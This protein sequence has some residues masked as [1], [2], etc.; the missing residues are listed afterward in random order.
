MNVGNPGSLY[1]IISAAATDGKLPAGFSLPKEQAAQS[2]LRFADGAADGIAMYHMQSP[3]PNKETAA[4]V[5]EAILAASDGLTDKADELFLALGKES[6]ALSLI[7]IL[8]SWIIEHRQTLSAPNLWN[9]ALHAMRDSGDK[10]CVKFGLSI[11]GVFRTDHNPSVR[12]VVKTLGL[13]DEFTLFAV[14]IM[15]TWRDRNDEIWDLARKVHGW[16]RIHAAERLEPAT[17]AIRS[18]FLTD[19]VRN[20]VNHAYSAL[21]CWRKGNAEETLKG[22]VTPDEFTGIG[23][24]LAAMLDD[25]PAEGITALKNADESIL[26]YLRAAQ[27]MPLTAEDYENIQ[28]L[29]DCLQDDR[30]PESE[31]IVRCRELLTSDAC[32]SAVSEAVKTGRCIELAI[33]L[34]IDCRAQILD[35]LK[36]DLQSKHWLSRYLMD[37]PDYRH[38]VLTLYRQKLPLDELKKAPG[39]SPGPGTGNLT[40]WIFEC[41]LW[42]LTEFPLEG[43]DF[44]ETGLHCDPVRTRNISLQVLEAWVSKTG[45]PLQNLLPEFHRLLSSLRDAEPDDRVRERMD[46]LLSGQTASK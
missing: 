13:S 44:I 43:Q 37:D 14:F 9:Y 36:S 10:E 29:R 40:Q 23:V 19:G 24:I 27:R 6:R 38:A 8:Q 45:N 22:S 2:E 39:A 16:G 5:G 21:T 12:S 11:L 15:S 3:N 4:K 41:L 33:E 32:R 28:K 20:D 31:I 25:G 42:Q 26:D 30:E 46:R 35:I 17:D 34:G 7:E 18:W 1:E